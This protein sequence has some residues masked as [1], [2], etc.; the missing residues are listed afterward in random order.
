MHHLLLASLSVRSP[1]VLRLRD[2]TTGQQV[3]LV[4]TVHYNPASVA[5]AKE[6]VALASKRD[7]SLGAVVVE[8]CTSRW[9]TSLEKAPP[10][11]LIA[12]L[13]CSEMQGA[14]GVALQKGVP[15]MLGDADAGAFLPRV[16]QLAQQSVRDLVSPFAGG[17]A[18][19][20]QDFGRT[21]PG[22]LNP[23]D[24]ASSEL[25]LEGERPIGIQDFLK[26][27]MLVG[28]LFSLIRYPAAFALKAP[29][30]FAALAAF[31]YA[32]E[33]TAIELDAATASSVAAGE[34]VSLPIVAALLFSA[35][36]TGLSVLVARLLLVA[37]LEE[38]NAELARSIRRAAA[39]KDA[40]VV[41]I[42]GGL[43]VNGV[44]RLLLSEATPDA[45]S[46]AY[47]RVADGVWWEPPPEVDASKWL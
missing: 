40:P 33:S 9:T 17:W 44:A 34:V 19:I 2:A 38:R 22:T 14:A 13:V 36:T 31:L 41:A 18:A 35:A 24:V 32:L 16:R 27:E 29:L 11:S 25:L 23:A 5:R 21:L 37:F 8:S 15:I 30:P 45:D 10:G 1:Q 39:E 7:R 42:L 28:F 12:N 26:P 3:S 46:L 4:G 43:H 20:V 47:D 6:E